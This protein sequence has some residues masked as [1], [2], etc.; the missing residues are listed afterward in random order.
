M[1]KKVVL[2]TCGAVFA[3]ALAGC[4]STNSNDTGNGGKATPPPSMVGPIEGKWQSTKLS[5]SSGKNLTT[6]SSLVFEIVKG[7]GY[8]G[9]D[10]S[11]EVSYGGGGALVSSGKV[12]TNFFG[13][14]WDYPSA[15]QVRL[16][17]NS[18]KTTI[19]P[20]G[21]AFPGSDVEY[22]EVYTYSRSGDVLTATLANDSNYCGGTGD[23]LTVV[24]AKQ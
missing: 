7:V 6:K 14:K 20:A 11:M 9:F 3:I 23:T 21:C 17:Y 12:C 8:A 22:T 2:V 4:G 13:A 5:C 19:T 18:S 16:V 1:L 10:D 24:F 15:N